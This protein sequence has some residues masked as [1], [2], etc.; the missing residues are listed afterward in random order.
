MS[1]ITCTE[2]TGSSYHYRVL[3]YAIYLLSISHSYV[4]FLIRSYDVPT[5]REGSYSV[6]QCYDETWAMLAQSKIKT[7]GPVLLFG[8]SMQ[9]WMLAAKSCMYK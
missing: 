8:T 6:A 9:Y 5:V 4:G 1:G 7:D 2:Y 3:G